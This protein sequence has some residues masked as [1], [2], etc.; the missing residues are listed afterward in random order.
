L[1]AHHDCRDGHA[2]RDHPCDPPDGLFLLDDL[3]LLDGRHH[4]DDRDHRDGRHHRDDRHHRDGRALLGHQRGPR[5]ARDLP[6]PPRGLRD[7]GHGQAC[8]CRLGDRGDPQAVGH[9]QGVPHQR[10]HADRDEGPGG[11]RRGLLPSGE[12]SPGGQGG[13]TDHRWIHHH[14]GPNDLPKDAD[15][16]LHLP[17]E[18]RGAQCRRRDG[19]GGLHRRPERDAPSYQDDPPT[20]AGPTMGDRKKAREDGDRATT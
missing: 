18:G 19:P 12:H 9:E 15:G 17:V 4:R 11:R 16:P 5:D 1:S 20:T 13:W 8:R 3:F 6:S 7:A 10:P 2:Q 14:A